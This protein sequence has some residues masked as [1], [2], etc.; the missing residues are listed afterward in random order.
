MLNSLGNFPH[1]QTKC[2]S[3][4]PDQ[5][6]T[7]S[8]CCAPTSHINPTLPSYCNTCSNTVLQWVENTTVFD[9]VPSKEKKMQIEGVVWGF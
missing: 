8:C 5:I 6:F 3:N 7:Q 9:K 4:F 2:Q 1:Q